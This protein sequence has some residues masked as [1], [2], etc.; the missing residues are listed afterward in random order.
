MEGGKWWDGRGPVAVF[1][2]GKRGRSG[3]NGMRMDE[4]QL[5]SDRLKLHTKDC[6]SETTSNFQ[7]INLLWKCCV[8]FPHSEKQWK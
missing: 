5:K 2:L 3:E 8:Q 6:L 1:Y 4:K 7:G